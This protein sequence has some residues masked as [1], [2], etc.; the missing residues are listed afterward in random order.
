[1]KFVF[2]KF[3]CRLN[4][5]WNIKYLLNALAMSLGLVSVIL[6]SVRA[7]GTEFEVLFRDN[8]FLILFQVFFKS[9]CLFENNL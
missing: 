4:Q 6:F 9:L 5:A 7:E 1:M 2:A 3:D 8:S